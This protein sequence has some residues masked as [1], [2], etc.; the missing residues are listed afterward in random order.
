MNRKNPH[1]MNQPVAELPVPLEFDRSWINQLESRLDKGGP[2][3]IT[4]S[5]NWAFKPKKPI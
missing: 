3:G 4:D 2:W 1:H 5:S